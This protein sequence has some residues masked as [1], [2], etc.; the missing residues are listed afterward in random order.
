MLYE[1]FLTETLRGG[2]QIASEMFGKVSGHLKDDQTLVTEADL[3]VGKFIISEIE[4][5]YPSHNII[6]EETGVIDKQSEYTWVIDP[7][8]G[9]ANFAVGVPFYGVMLGLLKGAES[10]AGG[11]A[12]PHFNDIYFAEKGQGAFCNGQRMALSDHSDFSAMSI[13]YGIDRFGGGR[14]L[15]L[16]QARYLGEM[17]QQFQTVRSSGSVYDVACLVKGSYGAVLFNSGKIWDYVADHVV[18]EESGCVVTDLNG[19]PMDFSDPLEKA[20]KKQI[21]TCCGGMPSVHKK[22]QEIIHNEK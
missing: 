7:I 14:E 6:N 22:L 8:D 1:K 11:F 4:K 5:V 16:R 2:A 18:I 20:G 9:T 13:A 15:E 19:K 21:Y 12:I 3:A 10:V 17:A